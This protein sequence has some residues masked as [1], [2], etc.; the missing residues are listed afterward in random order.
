MYVKNTILHFHTPCCSVR[1]EGN[2]VDIQMDRPLHSYTLLLS[3]N[4]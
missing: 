4:C 2:I 3:A 1:M